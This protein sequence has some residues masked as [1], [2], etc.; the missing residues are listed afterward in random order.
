MTIVF[1]EYAVWHRHLGDARDA[2]LHIQTPTL[3]SEFHSVSEMDLCQFASEP[4]EKNQP[5]RAAVRMRKA[6]E[7]VAKT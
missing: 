3:H 7:L 6:R 5:H 2:E 1:L 4:E